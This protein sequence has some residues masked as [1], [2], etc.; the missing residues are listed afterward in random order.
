[1][2]ERLYTTRRLSIVNALVAAI[3]S[4]DG[5]G[6]FESNLW[7][8]VSPR[9]KFW[10]EVSQFPSVHL[11]AGTEQRVYQG[12]GY[13]DRFLAVTVRVYVNEEDSVEALDRVMEDIETVVE[14]NSRLIYTDKQGNTQATHQI[15]IVSL[16]SDEGVLDPYGVGEILL[17]VQY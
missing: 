8:N 1:M 9:L 17:E 5:T 14:Q 4:I 12:G 13:K 6:A 3:K 7:N 16:E 15:S 10:D 11:N 2:T